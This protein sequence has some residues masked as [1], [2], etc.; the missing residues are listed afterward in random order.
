[1]PHADPGEYVLLRELRCQLP[2]CAATFYACLCCFWRYCSKE[3]RTRARLLNRRAANQRYQQTEAGRL[4]HND[5]QSDYRKRCRSR[6]AQQSVTDHSSISAESTSS[7]GHASPTPP[8]P[9]PAP[10]QAADRPIQVR[11]QRPLRCAICGRPGLTL[12]FWL[13][14]RWPWRRCR[15]PRSE[16]P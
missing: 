14:C 6:E 10:P 1:M 13:A 3:C 11:A 16:S 8:T 12:P 2:G 7:F 9:A 5:R 15:N 4:D